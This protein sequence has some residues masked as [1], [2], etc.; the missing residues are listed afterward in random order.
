[1]VYSV[2]VQNRGG[3]RVLNV[4]KKVVEKAAQSC[5][6]REGAQVSAMEEQQQETG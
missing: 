1:M 6:L 4:G 3:H 2:D 5:A